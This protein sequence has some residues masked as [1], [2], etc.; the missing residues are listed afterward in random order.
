MGKLILCS[1]KR[2]NRPYVLPAAGYRIYSI[3]ELCYYIYNNIYFIDEFFFS[4]SLV[5]WIGNELGLLERAEKLEQMVMQGADFKALLAV[6]LCS[7]DYYTEQELKKLLTAVD[8]I[9]AMPAA[10]RWYIKANSFLKR[11]QY[12]EAVAEYD[13]LL[14]SKEAV[15]LSPKDYGDVLHNYA[16]AKLHIYGP[17]RA[18]ESFLNAYERNRREES[19]RQYLYALW[20]S[21]DLEQFDEKIQEYHVS[22]ELREDIVLRMEQLSREARM[23]KAMDEINQLRNIKKAGRLPEVREE[24]G[25][26]IDKWIGEIRLL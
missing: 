15:D 5:D 12:P 7:S 20:L 8:E 2:T 3:E 10:K 22:N 18:V 9:R 24:C 19:L 14:I 1:G 23:S 4:V 26:I 17:E 11:K 25:R 21:R 6:V 13:R 16:V